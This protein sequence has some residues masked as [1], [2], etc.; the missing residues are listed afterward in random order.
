[1]IP[2]DRA[3]TKFHIWVRMDGALTEV[4]VTEPILRKLEPLI[5]VDLPEPDD[6]LKAEL[7]FGELEGHEE[8][9][10]LRPPVEARIVEVNEE[11]VWNHKKLLK[12]PYGAGWMLRIRPHEPE[13]L[14]K[15][16]SPALY[17]TFCLDDL[18]EEYVDA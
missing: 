12:D 8:T 7:A 15:L 4:G 17:R 3:Y 13:R 1:M 2:E 11:L 6:E 14:T 9:F 16:W 10:H 5:S 18:G